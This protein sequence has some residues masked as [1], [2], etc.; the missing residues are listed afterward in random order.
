MLSLAS[1]PFRPGGAIRS[2]AIRDWLG[3]AS[4]PRFEREPAPIVVPIRRFVPYIRIT[5]ASSR[6]E[7]RRVS[8]DFPDRHRFHSTIWHSFRMIG[9]SVSPIIAKA[10]FGAIYMRLDRR[11]FDADD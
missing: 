6:C 11:R 10:I 5:R 3:Q 1:L 4:V 7:R 8:K 9:N 2:G